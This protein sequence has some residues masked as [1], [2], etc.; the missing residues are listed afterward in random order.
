[1]HRGSCLCGSIKYAIDDSLKFIVNCHCG[2]CRKAHGAPFTTLLFMPFAKF[3]LLE[4]QELLA[5]YEVKALNALR[6]F[7]SRCATRLY[8]HSPS[9]GMISLMVATLDTDAQLRP[10][11][12]INVGSR[13]PWHELADSLPQFHS[14][15]SQ[16]EFGELL[17]GA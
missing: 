11:A 12:N 10:L 8:N 15:P 14:V 4:G 6:C 16:E 13:C 3:E 1:M 7:C 9:R 17:S 5:S 2:F